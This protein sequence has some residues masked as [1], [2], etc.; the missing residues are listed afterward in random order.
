MNNTILF[1][2]S[3]SA[4]LSMLRCSGESA[5]IGRGTGAVVQGFHSPERLHRALPNHGS[6]AVAFRVFRSPC[7]SPDLNSN[8]CYI[9]PVSLLMIGG[10]STLRNRPEV[11][12][13][14]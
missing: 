11:S 7:S 5:I 6:V 10:A 1:G 4:G 3:P 14:Q 12:P 13:V 2:H 8:N 9:G